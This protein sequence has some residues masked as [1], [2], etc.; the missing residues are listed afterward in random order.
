M[1]GLTGNAGV[2]YEFT[3]HTKTCECPQTPKV[4]AT[5]RVLD[6]LIPKADGYWNVW[7]G[8]FGDQ[9]VWI[10]MQIVDRRDGTVIWRNGRLTEGVSHGKKLD[11]G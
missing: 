4:F 7:L 8:F 1:S 3:I 6:R 5:A 11:V 10:I 9:A 2:V